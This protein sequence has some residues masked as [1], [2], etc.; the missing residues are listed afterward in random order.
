VGLC[1][2]IQVTAVKGQRAGHFHRPSAPRAE[3]RNQPP[4]NRTCQPR[5]KLYIHTVTPDTCLWL[6]IRL[7]RLARE[8]FAEERCAL[9]RLA[10]WAYQWSSLI[11]YAPSGEV[12]CEPLL[13]LELGASCALF[14]GHL[15][16]LAAI[17]SELAQLGL[18]HVCAL[19]PSPRPRHC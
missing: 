12:S 18:S 4:S 5:G 1:S 3:P 8:A 16:L 14:Q 6:C 9:E 17:E 2:V 10:A 15:A 19:A 7:P 13:W 11:S